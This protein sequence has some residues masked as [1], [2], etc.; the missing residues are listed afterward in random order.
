[1]VVRFASAQTDTTKQEQKF[2]QRVPVDTSGQKLN[3][4]ATYNR[5][6]LSMGKSPV[7]IG[8][9]LEAN[10]EYAQTDGISEG[11]TFQARRMTLFFSSTIGNRLS[12]LSEIEFENGTEEINIEFAALDVEFHPLANFRFGIIVNPIGAFNQNHDG[13]R[14][15]F[16]DRPLEA[17][18]IIPSTLSN[19]GFGLHGKHV[20]GNWIMGYETYLTNGFDD[21]IISNEESR[22]SLA[23]SAE[24][25]DRFT[26]NN[27]GLPM[28][29]GKLGAKNRK[30]GEFGISYM[31]GV[32][33]KWK[34]DGVTIDE[35]RVVSV[36]AFDYSTSLLNDQLNLTGEVA[37]VHVEVPD[38]YSQQFGDQQFGAYLDIVATLL[39]GR[40]IGWEKA[41]LNLGVRIEYV[42]YNVGTFRETGDNI[43]DD[44]WAV[45]PSLAFRPV[46]S[47]VIRFN[48]RY[49]WQKDLFGNPPARTGV[50]QF[51]I[52][53]Y[54]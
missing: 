38:S 41:K 24:N 50:I 16:I 31:S 6:F 21:K 20:A 48:Y 4:D 26:E 18:T 7:S 15:D 32:Y 44:I 46:G 34:E 17:T 11:F 25:I 2:L 23:A 30:I 39:H 5:P 37:S 22:T 29:T 42:D 43:A 35:K 54:F 9:Y 53:T 13:P 47:T 12:F 3:M 10:T 45:V 49:E 33:N 27:S 19:A 51:G 52:A 1:M 28:F 8:G 40:M 14:W 36:I